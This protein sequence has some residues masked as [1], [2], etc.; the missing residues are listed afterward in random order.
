[1]LHIIRT[2]LGYLALVRTNDEDGELVMLAGPNVAL[3]DSGFWP[4]LR[5]KGFEAEMR[6]ENP[7]RWERMER[8]GIGHLRQEKN[9]L[10]RSG[11]TRANAHSRAP[12]PGTVEIT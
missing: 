7:E 1:M 3:P 6:A 2:S 9:V 8:N 10:A 4:L 5:A 12:D 11:L